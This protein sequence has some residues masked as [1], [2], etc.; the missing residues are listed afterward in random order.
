MALLDLFTHIF[1]VVHLKNLLAPVSHSEDL[2]ALTRVNL[3]HTV[4]LYTIQNS[5]VLMAI[6][7][8]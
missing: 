5:F 2:N 3:H 7:L 4:C 1:E 8:Q 6:Y